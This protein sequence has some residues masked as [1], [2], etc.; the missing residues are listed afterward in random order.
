MEDI[1][2]E[3]RIINQ[4]LSNLEFQVKEG[5]ENRKDLSTHFRGELQAHKLEIACHLNSRFED[6]VFA[7]SSRD[8]QQRDNPTGN[9]ALNNLS[10][11]E[12]AGMSKLLIFSLLFSHDNDDLDH[13]TTIVCFKINLHVNTLVQNFSFSS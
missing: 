4:R 9:I 11:G 1:I 12:S 10:S 3:L 8:I 6:D 5:E 2:K 7:S 13:C